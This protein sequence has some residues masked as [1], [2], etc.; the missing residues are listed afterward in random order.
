[1]PEA[2]QAEPA[3]QPVEPAAAK[4]E[5]DKP[6]APSERG[7]GTGSKVKPVTIRVGSGRQQAVNTDNDS[8][9]YINI[10]GRRIG[11]VSRA[12]AREL[13]T[14]ELKGTLTEADLD[15]YTGA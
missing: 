12:E 2:V 3:Q 10:M 14:K 1:L 15:K 7:A 11:P 9:L 6:A 4:P 5:A 13:K 8:S